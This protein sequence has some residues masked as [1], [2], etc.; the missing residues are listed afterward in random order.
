MAFFGDFYHFFFPSFYGP[1]GENGGYLYYAQD[2]VLKH[3]PLE[4]P[5]VSHGTYNL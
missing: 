5:R 1:T 2:E 3:I 4:S